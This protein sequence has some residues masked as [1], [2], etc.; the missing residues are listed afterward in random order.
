LPLHP[1]FFSSSKQNLP[2]NTHKTEKIQNIHKLPI[3]KPNQGKQI[4]QKQLLYLIKNCRQ[5]LL[6]Q[7]YT[8]T[9]PKPSQPQ[10]K[11]TKKKTPSPNSSQ[12]QLQFKTPT[13]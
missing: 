12:K 9:R 7:F 5:Q 13:P 3:I 4:H 10:T 6:L 8:K 2:P 1:T 11:K